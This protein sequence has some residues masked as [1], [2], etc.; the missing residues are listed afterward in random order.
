MSYIGVQV[1]VAARLSATIADQTI[2][3]RNVLTVGS[4]RIQILASNYSGSIPTTGFIRLN[5]FAPQGEVTS[6]GYDTSTGG[7]LEFNIFVESGS[8]EGR[9][10][11]FADALETRFGGVQSGLTTFGKGS[12]AVKGIDSENPNLWRI[13]LRIPFTRYN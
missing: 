3:S 5:T 2:D 7:F 4:D 11:R 10:Y 1:D 8:G 12:I 6:F 13:D 9:G